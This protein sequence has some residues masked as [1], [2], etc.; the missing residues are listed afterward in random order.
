MKVPEKCECV[1]CPE[2]NGQGEIWVSGDY[3]SP[4]RFDD[5]GDYET[6]SFCGGDGLHYYCLKCQLEED[7]DD[8]DEEWGV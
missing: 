5:M 8:D 7:E 3:S 4:N 1:N 6:C 2:C